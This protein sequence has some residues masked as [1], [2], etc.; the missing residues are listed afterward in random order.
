MDKIDNIDMGA[1]LAQLRTTAAA[2]QT[3]AT[4]AAVGAVGASQETKTDFSAV[5]KQSVDAVNET[6]KAAGALSKA[7]AQGD[8]NVSLEQVM[9]AGQ[10]ASISFQAMLQ[11]R[12]K[13][14]TA[15][16]EIMS[17]QV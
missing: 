3:G 7:L 9:I 5:L 2:A 1:L 16:Q 14:V 4:G 10:K 8:S 11:V 15:Y 6:Q 17:M 13:M 12:N